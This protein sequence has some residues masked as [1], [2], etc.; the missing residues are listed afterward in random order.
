VLFGDPLASNVNGWHVGD[1][2]SFQSDGYH[3][4]AN[5]TCLAPVNTPADADVLVQAE[6][7][8]GSLR[9]GYGLEL[10]ASI[11]K[12]SLNGYA[13]VI[14]SAG[15]WAFFK[16]AG[17]TST[18]IVPFVPSSAIHAG[19]SVTNILEVRMHVAHFDFFINGMPVGQADDSTYASGA[20]GLS[21]NSN[22]EV[23][24]TNYVI[25]VTAGTAYHPS[26]YPSHIPGT[27]CPGPARLIWQDAEQE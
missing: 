3:I 5:V 18:A 19:S 9:E 26:Q 22:I 17:G 20:S 8:S 7:I 2:C 10:R 15:A 4:N 13:F 24:Y 14:A 12:N 27:F 21:G 6:Q 1:G 16:D 25:T 11:S 23:V